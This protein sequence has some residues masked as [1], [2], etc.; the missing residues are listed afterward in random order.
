MQPTDVDHPPP[1]NHLLIT[2]SFG[3]ILTDEMLGQ[4]QPAHRLNVH[5]SLLPAYRGPAPLQR[6]VL[7]QEKETGVC[8]IKMLK[9][10]E[11]I[12]AG[13]IWGSHKIVRCSVSFVLTSMCI[14]NCAIFV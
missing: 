1:A 5:P 8:V 6:A 7:N 13:S 12:D 4:F 2:A 11:G 14:K 9:K 3:R 10:S